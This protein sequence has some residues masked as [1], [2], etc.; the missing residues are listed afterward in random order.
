MSPQEAECGFQGTHIDIGLLYRGMSS[1]LRRIS[2]RVCIVLFQLF[3]SDLLNSWGPRV[4]LPV[5][6]LVSGCYLTYYLKTYFESQ[7]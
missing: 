2:W 4:I 3:F 1:F 6:V 7:S 5:S